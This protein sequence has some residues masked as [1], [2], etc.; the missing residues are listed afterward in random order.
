MK[1]RIRENTLRIRLTQS[2]IKNIEEGLEVS[3]YLLFPNN[4]KLSYRI[5]SHNNPLTTLNYF[6]NTI[7]IMLGELDRETLCDP[8]AV[9]VQNMHST[10]G[11]DL[12][13][14]IEKDFNCLH[15]RDGEDQDTFPHPNKNI[16]DFS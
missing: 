6:E 11:D 5:T 12:S 14:L 1:L 2:E 13:L 16:K 8:S 7:Q 10:K 3:S 9:G 4:G 15:P